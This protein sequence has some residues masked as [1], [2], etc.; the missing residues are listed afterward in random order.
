MHTDAIGA[1]SMDRVDYTI[2]F[3][4]RESSKTA[5]SS[6]TSAST[7]AVTCTATSAT[8][9]PN[10]TGVITNMKASVNDTTFYIVSSC[11]NVHRGPT[12]RRE[13]NKSSGSQLTRILL[14]HFKID[15]ITIVQSHQRRRKS[16]F[17]FS[18]D[19]AIVYHRES[20]WTNPPRL[21]VDK[22]AKSAYGLQCIFLRW[23]L[24]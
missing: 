12:R 6:I 1:T 7:V 21:V 10:Y 8:P 3:D 22:K 9:A 16:R 5:S 15:W 19:F 24:P 17:E 20:Q 23:Q 2:A 4:A 11:R 14:V 13:V 18:C